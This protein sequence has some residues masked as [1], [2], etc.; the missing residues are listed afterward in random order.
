LVSHI[1]GGADT[2]G[3]EENIWRVLRKIFGSKNE[4]DRRMEK[5]TY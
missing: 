2:E 5:I 1:K 3:A 4:S